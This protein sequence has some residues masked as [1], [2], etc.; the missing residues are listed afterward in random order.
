MSD[1][2]YVITKSY[3]VFRLHLDTEF[4]T[5]KKSS[6]QNALLGGNKRSSVPSQLEV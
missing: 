2:E 1:D 4:V 5:E 3:F 6:K